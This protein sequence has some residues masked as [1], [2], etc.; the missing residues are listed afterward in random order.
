MHTLLLRW[1]CWWYGV[2]DG[3]GH[4]VRARGGFPWVAA[5]IRLATTQQGRRVCRHRVLCVRD[6]PRRRAK[7]GTRIGGKRVWITFAITAFVWASCAAVQCVPCVCLSECVVCVCVFKWL[8]PLVIWRVNFV[9]LRQECQK[10]ILQNKCEY[11]KA[12]QVSWR[13]Q[14]GGFNKRPP[15]MSV[16]VIEWLV[17]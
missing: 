11:S 14:L 16:L 13:G 3:Y 15:R 17:I 10:H 4:D 12:V 5:Y 9:G 6:H 2:C 8:R 1:W 7:R